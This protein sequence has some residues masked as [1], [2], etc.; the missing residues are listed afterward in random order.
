MESSARWSAPCDFGKCV[1][2]VVFE[3]AVDL[4][5]IRR[6]NQ[7]SV[8][9]H[10]FPDVEANH[11]KLQWFYIIAG[12]FV[13]STVGLRN[14]HG[15]QIVDEFADHTIGILAGRIGRRIPDG[16]GGH[17]ESQAIDPVAV[18]QVSRDQPR[19]GIKRSKIVF[20]QNEER[21]DT[22]VVEQLAKLKK[23]ARLLSIATGS[24][25]RTSSN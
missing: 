7:Q 23:K 25:R 3:G 10:P 19:I 8:R 12:F 16:L 2:V 22:G 11:L 4:A 17:L 14:L 5:D 6:T 18:V 9:R 21:P 20:P 24:T 1:V 13:Q 15:G